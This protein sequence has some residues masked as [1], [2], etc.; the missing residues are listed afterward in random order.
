M[1]KPFFVGEERLLEFEQ[2]YYA[3]MGIQV[4]G[5]QKDEKGYK[6]LEDVLHEWNSILNRVS[7]YLH[8]SFDEV[9]K[10]VEFPVTAESQHRFLQI[11][12]NDKP[13]ED[14]AFKKLSDSPNGSKWM[15][16][17][18]SKKFFDGNKNPGPKDQALICPWKGLLTIAGVQT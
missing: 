4:L 12:R 1:L 16:L 3:Q 10:I 11:I 9:D 8:S 13:L 5:F 7:G 15:L 2:T 18:K 6:Q 14:Y 17:L